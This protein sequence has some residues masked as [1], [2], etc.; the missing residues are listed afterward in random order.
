MFKKIKKFL[1][2]HLAP[3]EVYVRVESP[4]EY[5]KYVN[6][7]LS[8]ENAELKKKIMKLEKELKKR[9]EVIA[10]LQKIK[11]K[12]IEEDIKRQEKV[13]KEIK[14]AKRFDILFDLKRPVKLISTLTGDTFYDAYGNE[15]SF[16]RGIRLIHTNYGPYFRFLLSSKPKGSYGSLA[17]DIPLENFSNVF[18]N[19]FRLIHELK[20]GIVEVNITPEGE[21]FQGIM[22]IPVKK[23]SSNKNN[24]DSDPPDE[25]E[26]LA[27][28]LEIDINLIKEFDPKI[29]RGIIQIYREIGR[30]RHQLKEAMISEKQAWSENVQLKTEL[31]ASKK[32]IDSLKSYISQLEDKYSE[33]QRKYHQIRLNLDEAQLKSTI[34]ELSFIYLTDAVEKLYAKLAERYGEDI[35]TTIRREFERNISMLIEQVSQ[36]LAS[37]P[38]E[39][40]PPKVEVKAGGG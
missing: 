24:P 25:N 14:K 38:K 39:I 19:P 8:Y 12:E 22:R 2:K 27:K 37:I 26:P 7:A 9:E 4:E 10:D 3:R 32:E 16:L 31:E 35:A 20:R 5:K 30:L 33:I 40:M 1:A 13:L 6:Q 18:S 34:H 17:C 11:E 15:K 21:F 28:M 36:V 29:A 23:E